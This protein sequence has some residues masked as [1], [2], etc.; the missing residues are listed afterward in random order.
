[1]QGMSYGSF[2]H[3]P[4]LRSIQ[5]LEKCVLRSAGIGSVQGAN[6]LNGCLCEVISRHYP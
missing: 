6:S 2:A 4:G 5:A 1:M 3:Q